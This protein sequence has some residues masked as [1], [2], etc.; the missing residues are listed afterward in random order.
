MIFARRGV[1]FNSLKIMCLLVIDSV[2][3]Y[4]YVG[5]WENDHTCGPAGSQPTTAAG[6][7]QREVI[8]NI[9][10]I[11]LSTFF[12]IFYH[13]VCFNLILYTLR[14]CLI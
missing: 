12:C 10:I 6:I 5:W 8:S 14:C 2:V 13:F 7:V 11:S 4:M 3:V 1:R 9:T